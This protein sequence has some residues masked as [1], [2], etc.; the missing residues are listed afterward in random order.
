MDPLRDPLH[1]LVLEEALADT[2][3]APASTVAAG[4]AEATTD[5]AAEAAGADDASEASGE[6]SVHSTLTAALEA[7]DRSPSPSRRGPGPYGPVPMSHPLARQYIPTLI[8]AGPP[9]LPVCCQRVDPQD[10]DN[11]LHMTAH[12]GADEED[13]NAAEE[14]EE[15]EDCSPDEDP[16]EDPDDS[17]DGP[18]LTGPGTVRPSAEATTPAP[19]S[20]ASGS[21][22]IPLEALTG[23]RSIRPIGAAEE[24]ENP[25]STRRTVAALR[26]GNQRSETQTMQTGAHRLC[27]TTSSWDLGRREESA[28]AE[29]GGK[30][31]KEAAEE[32]DGGEWRNFSYSNSTS[33][34]DLRQHTRNLH[35]RYQGHKPVP[36]FGALMLT[37]D[38][39]QAFDRMP[40]SKLYDGMCRL[41]LPQDL[42]H[43][44]MAWHAEIRYTIRHADDQRTFRACHG[45]RQGCS[46]APLL[47]LIFSHE[48]S[49][50]LEAKVGRDTIIRIPTIFADDYHMAD[51]FTSL[52]AF[53]HLLDVVAVLFHVLTAFGMEV[54]AGKSKAIL[55]LRGTLSNTIRKKYVRPA[56]DGSGQVLRIQSRHQAFCI[57][58]V[59]QFTYLGTQ[60]SYSCFEQQTLTSRLAKGET[61]YHRLGAVLKGRHHLTQAQRL[62]LWKSCVWT[63]VSYGLIACGLHE[64]G[65][66]V[67]NV[68]MTKQLRAI[69]K[70]P[71]HIINKNTKR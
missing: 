59:S 15:E 35:L 31:G 40:R 5:G 41:D 71:V 56:Q 43:T 22:E 53:E 26:E 36:L 55:A 13:S 70:L 62:H 29:L 34:I 14:G 45:I 18:G 19:G 54:S 39:T 8:P 9:A 7:A 60:V 61:C 4:V 58:L 46:V 63:T 64:T 48:V 68:A 3:P 28:T 21:L 30:P 49:C 23:L 33:S 44:L 65:I 17:L 25:F 47:W 69:L 11:P 67:L 50:A 6:G 10:L 66:K 12:P 2:G 37:V 52:V 27:S 57:P 1:D 42:I 20:A 24:T 32:E 51:A 38:L 16:D